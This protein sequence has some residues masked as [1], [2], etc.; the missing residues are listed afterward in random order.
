MGFSRNAQHLRSGYSFL[1]KGHGLS[2]ITFRGGLT[3]IRDGSRKH[4][5]LVD[6]DHPVFVWPPN[7]L[8]D[9]GSHVCVR[10]EVE[11]WV[12]PN[13]SLLANKVEQSR[14]WRTRNMI[15]PLVGWANWHLLFLQ[16][17]REL[18][19]YW[20]QTSCHVE[21]REAG[22]VSYDL[23]CLKFHYRSTLLVWNNFS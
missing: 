14:Q 1:C 6:R 9:P 18:R 17:K 3:S 12:I 19:H 13:A 10:D 5:S 4:L 15:F 22:Q 8:L 20:V 16:T 11:A 7:Y 2:V 23:G 21:K